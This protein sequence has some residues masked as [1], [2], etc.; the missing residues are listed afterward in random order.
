[1]NSLKKTARIA[2]LLYLLIAICAPFSMLYMPSKL[3][4]AGDAAATANNIT[5]SPLLFRAGVVSDAVVFL[6]EIVLVGLLYVLFKPVNPTLALIAAFSRLAMTVVQGINLLMYCFPVLL[7]S[8]A[9][10][11]AVFK[12]DQM[13]AL[14]LLFLN[15]HAYGAYIWG[16]FFGLHCLFLGIL[17]FQSGYFPRIV[18]LL[19]CILVICSGVGYLVQ[20]LGNL[21]LPASKTVAVISG[22][23]LTPGTIGELLLTFWLLIKGVKEQP[24]VKRKGDNE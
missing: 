23:L 22:V 14:V 8:G 6:M 12:T 7:L 5:A 17:L 24:V 20:S 16:S 13:Q 4:V 1:M 9:G 3:I 18:G 10:Y 19:L 11:L 15:A 21:L 2:G